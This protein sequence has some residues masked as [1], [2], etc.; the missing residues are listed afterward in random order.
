MKSLDAGTI[1]RIPENTQ[2][3]GD[4]IYLDEFVIGVIGPLCPAGF[5]ELVA[6]ASVVTLGRERMCCSYCDG[7]G[8]YELDGETVCC[9][10][11][12]GCGTVPVPEEWK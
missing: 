11:C 12:D 3:K 9:S 8:T 10:Y 5:M 4:V 2:R 7:T 1:I 6:S